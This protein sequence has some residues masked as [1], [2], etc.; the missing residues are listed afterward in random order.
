MKFAF[1]CVLVLL[2]LAIAP[3]MA[4]DMPGEVVLGDLDAPR[5]LA[6]DAD[7]NLLVAVAG[8]GGEVELTVP[9]PEGESTAGLGLTGRII[10]IAPD[11]SVTD[12]IPGL[13]S[14]A[15]A[16]ETLGVYRIIPQGESLWVVFSGFGAATIGAY[17]TDSVVELDA[18]TLQTKRIINLNNFEAAQD[19]DGNGYDSNVADIA[20]G[21][22]GT[23]YIV[24]AGCNCLASWTEADGLQ[25]VQAWPDNP[26]PTS[27]EI[28]ESGDFYIG[29][30]GAGLA[31][32]AGKIEHWS[33]G[34]LVETF[35]NLNAV[36]DILLDGDTLYAVQLV[37]FGEQGPGPGSVVTVSADGAT[38]VAEGL[39]APFGIA[40]GP[41]GALY[42]TYG[43]IVFAPDQT[44]GVLRLDM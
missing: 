25:T 21:A 34:E 37:V 20:W 35:G 40:K 24:N 28:A 41:D 1:V 6:F 9:G 14:Y 26:V 33:N 17:W 36:S 16:T 15:M 4:Q 27:I 11:G 13:P 10:S 23:L 3:A 38:P 31:P 2:G 5:A 42:V 44:G 8:S 32:G 19:P 29:F 39:P 30:L 22:D 7:G 18:A 43:T 12:L